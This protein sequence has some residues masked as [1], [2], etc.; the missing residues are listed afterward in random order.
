MLRTVAYA[1]NRFTFK[2]VA[3]NFPFCISY[4]ESICFDVL[5]FTH[6]VKTSQLL[7][8][9]RCAITSS[10]RVNLSGNNRFYV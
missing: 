2:D 8:E 9:D 1:N 4:P 5:R 3:L 7:K 6:A 10:K